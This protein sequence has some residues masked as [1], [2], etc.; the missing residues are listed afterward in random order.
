MRWC[1]QKYQSYNPNRRVN[2]SDM[3]VNAS[4]CASGGKRV[5]TQGGPFRSLGPRP[6]RAL[7]PGRC[8]SISLTFWNVQRDAMRFDFTHFLEC[9]DMGRWGAPRHR[10]AHG[11]S[12]SRSHLAPTRRLQHSARR[13][14]RGRGRVRVRVRVRLRVRVRGTGRVSLPV[15][16]V[17]GGG[18]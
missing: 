12:W 1:Q 8:A 14:V 15:R 9:G 6:S 3:Q 7:P 16:P 18:V 11:P 13:L 2:A 5:A 10:S 17:A 4:E